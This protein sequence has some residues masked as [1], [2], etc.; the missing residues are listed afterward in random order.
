MRHGGSPAK[1]SSFER[2]VC[3][4]LSLWVTKGKA[5][6]VFWRS[7]MS[8][9]RATLHLKVGNLIRQCGDICAVAPEGF[10]FANHWFVECKHVK[11]LFIPSFLISDTGDLAKFWDKTLEQA[12]HH[13]K[14]PMIIAR[15]N[16]SPILVITKVGHLDRYAAALLTSHAR[17][18]DITLYSDLIKARYSDPND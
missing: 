13:H 16:N 4:D 18:C 8:G 2:K 5:G 15:Q 12:Q 11:N 6:D 1:G 17:G 14:V 9:G 3:K 10:P 7:A